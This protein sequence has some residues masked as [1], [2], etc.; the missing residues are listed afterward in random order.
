MDPHDIRIHGK[1]VKSPAGNFPGIPPVFFSDLTVGFLSGNFPD[2]RKTVFP[3]KNP[4]GTF[5][6]D[7]TATPITYVMSRTAGSAT[8]KEG[9]HDTINNEN[10]PYT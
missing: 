8:A 7:E 10:K 4:D 3:T 1:N 6:R 5:R 9:N 2:I